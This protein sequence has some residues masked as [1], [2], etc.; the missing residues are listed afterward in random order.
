MTITESN[1][2]YY[3]SKEL[4]EYMIPK[5]LIQLNELPLTT[6]GKVDRQKLTE[7]KLLNYRSSVRYVSPKSNLEIEISKIWKEILKLDNVGVNDNFFELGG[8]SILATHI[9]ARV[10][11]AFQ[12]DM[13]MEVLFTETF[14]VAGLTGAVEQLQIEQADPAEVEKIL[15]ELDGLSDEELKSLLESEV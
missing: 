1:L 2:K 12:I 11:E 13:P 8:D 5:Y 4:P 10:R 9:L 7:K 15:A 6:T 3:L 14:T